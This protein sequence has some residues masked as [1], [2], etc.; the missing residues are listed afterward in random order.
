[1][2]IIINIPKRFFGKIIKIWN[3]IWNS[4]L[5]TFLL[6]LSIVTIMTIFLTSYAAYNNGVISMRSDDILQYYPYMSGFY[7]KLKSGTMSLYDKS[8]L[9]GA[10]WFSGAYYVQIDI[11]TFF[12]F[13]LSLFMNNYL[14]YTISNFLHIGFGALIFYI[15]LARKINNKAAFIGGIVMLVGGIVQAYYIFPVYLGINF[16]AP[17]GMLL[18]DLIVEKRKKYFFLIPIYALIVVLFDFYIA[19][20][21]LAFFCFYFV[22]KCHESDVFSLFGKNT[23]IKNK[24]FWLLFIK[25]MFFVLLGVMISLFMLLPSA[26]YILNESSRQATETNE[27]MWYFNKAPA[28]SFEPSALA[29]KRHYFTQLINL[30]IPNAP[31]EFM[32]VTTEDYVREHASL[33]ITSGALIYLISFFFIWGKKENRLK[34]WVIIINVMLLM[35]IFSI[36]LALDS[37]PYVRWFFMP[38]MMNLYVA[39][40]AMDKNNFRIGVK[41]NY[42][43]LIPLAVM[44]LG[45][46]LITYTLLTNTEYFIHYDKNDEIFK[47]ILI[48]SL[49]FCFIYIGIL[50]TTFI[51]DFKWKESKFS[52][53]LKYSIPLVVMFEFIFANIIIFNTIEGI[54]SY[55]YYALTSM[56]AQKKHLESLG[57][58]EKDGYRINI[59]SNY[60][61]GFSN[62]D[63]ALGN[64]NFGRYFQSFYNTEIND[65]L[66]EFY[67]YTR[68]SE[69]WNKVFNYGYNLTAAPIFNVK[70]VISTDS[71]N[72]PDKYYSCDVKDNV[73]Y[74]T[75][76]DNNPFIVYDNYFTDFNFTG[77]SSYYFYKQA[78]LLNSCYV[79]PI[80]QDRE[81]ITDKKTKEYYDSYETIKNYNIEA[82]NSTSIVNELKNYIYKDELKNSDST[83]NNEYFVY[84]LNNTTGNILQSYDVLNVYPDS[85]DDRKL[86]DGWMYYVIRN[87]DEDGNITREFYQ[88]HYNEIFSNAIIDK[89]GNKRHID[90]LWVQRNTKTS[91]GKC[92]VCA[93]NFDLYDKYLEN[94]NKYLDKEFELDGINMKIKFKNNDN[95]AKIIKTA[96]AYSPDWK[97]KTDG[98]ETVLVDDSFLGI[99]VK[100]GISD[101]NIEL[102][103]EPAGYQT[104]LNIA[105]L[106]LVIYF[107]TTSIY[108]MYHTR[109]KEDLI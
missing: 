24:E 106:G 18:I 50:L 26:L 75:L 103:Y 22:V 45:A 57:Y 30:Y 33:Y 105:I 16:Y 61:R 96:F 35:P 81:L 97:I 8:L 109:T 6:L 60:G 98:Y 51:I 1:M 15:F 73:K 48:P 52:N 25:F 44:I 89:A 69:Y 63:I 56:S 40:L 108:V 93:F 54:S 23:I 42:I 70:Y 90:E 4:K 43:K 19:Y 2:E 74:Y 77:Y 92:Y 37:D 12:G 21:L 68:E 49:I 86:N 53:Y 9:I 41:C 94:Q 95:N 99:M 104:G 28:L 67:G 83:I 39:C 76:K 32:L 13:L 7:D 82:T 10:S 87:T 102:R 11:F 47:V 34:L 91:N 58:D 66:K 80:Y 3:A 27:S 65:L 55:D 101:V 59:Y 46:F 36:I 84:D 20:M 64:T 17:L 107:F 5:N 79:K 31:H 85:W 78:A 72:L 71:I 38:F 88:G 29:T 100:D 14:A 62:L